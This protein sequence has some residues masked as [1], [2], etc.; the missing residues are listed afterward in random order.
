MAAARPSLEVWPVN[1]IC[2]GDAKGNKHIKGGF[3][4]KNRM[5]KSKPSPF[6]TV[7]LIQQKKASY[8]MIERK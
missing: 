1:I 7:S 4:K 2:S 5:F 8:H 6:K 3:R